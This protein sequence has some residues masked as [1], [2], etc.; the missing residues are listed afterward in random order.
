MRLHGFNVRSYIQV[1]II[2]PQSKSAVC[3]FLITHRV[4]LL[5]WKILKEILQTINRSRA[6]NQCSSMC[7]QIW[8]Q[9]SQQFNAWLSIIILLIVTARA[10]WSVVRT[11]FLPL[12][13]SLRADGRFIYW[14]VSLMVAN[15]A[16]ISTYTCK[17]GSCACT[18]MALCVFSIGSAQPRSKL[19]SVS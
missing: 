17:F 7:C 14:T 15:S 1:S 11:H 18:P 9:S 13:F 16:W 5:P 2:A 6:D 12:S 4:L 3:A 10:C 8:W 19:T